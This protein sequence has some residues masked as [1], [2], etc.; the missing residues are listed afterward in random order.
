MKLFS[1]KC[2]DNISR[3]NCNDKTWGCVDVTIIF[4]DKLEGVAYRYP[5]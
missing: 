5:R 2:P 4:I 1:V 3:T